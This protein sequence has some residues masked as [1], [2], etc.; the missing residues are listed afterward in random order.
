MIRGFRLGAWGGPRRID[1]LDHG[2]DLTVEAFAVLFS[3]D[4]GAAVG[5]QSVAQGGTALALSQLNA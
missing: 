2:G 1:L 4:G 5:S 3:V